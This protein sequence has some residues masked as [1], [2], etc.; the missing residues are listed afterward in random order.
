MFGMFTPHTIKAV[1]LPVFLQ[2]HDG[3][4]TIVMAALQEILMTDVSEDS[5]LLELFWAVY[6][7]V[8]FL[9]RKIY[10]LSF[11]LNM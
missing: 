2:N 4:F 1:T 11:S 5:I 9:N 7:V 10:G 8:A 6:Y 3:F